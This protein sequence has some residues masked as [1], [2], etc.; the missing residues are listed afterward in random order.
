M[1]TNLSTNLE[2]LC[3]ACHIN[4]HRKEVVPHEV[5]K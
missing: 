3:R 4:E 1:N 5:V 2:V